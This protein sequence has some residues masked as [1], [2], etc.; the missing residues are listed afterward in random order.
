M[1]KDEDARKSQV[2]VAFLLRL[3]SHKKVKLRVMYNVVIAVDYASMK[4]RVR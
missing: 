3:W 2:S 1:Q 4:D